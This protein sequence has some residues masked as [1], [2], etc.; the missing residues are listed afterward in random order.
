MIEVQSL[1]AHV[2]SDHFITLFKL[3]NLIHVELDKK[4]PRSHM[5][6]ASQFYILPIQPLLLKVISRTN[7]WLPHSIKYFPQT[8]KEKEK[9]K[10]SCSSLKQLACKETKVGQSHSLPLSL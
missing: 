6:R 9:K 5:Y 8:K 2:Y 7:Q 10:K 3:C 4:N 1:H